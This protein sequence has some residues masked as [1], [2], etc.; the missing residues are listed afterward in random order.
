ME[1]V[2]VAHTFMYIS[3]LAACCNYTILGSDSE[4]CLNNIIVDSNC[5]LNTLLILFLSTNAIKNVSLVLSEWKGGK[6]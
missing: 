3:T 2:D 5:C 4:S 6:G 1:T